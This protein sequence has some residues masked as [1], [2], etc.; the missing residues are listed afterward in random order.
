MIV[1]CKYLIMDFHYGYVIKTVDLEIW[2][3]VLF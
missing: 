2:S 1:E 3:A